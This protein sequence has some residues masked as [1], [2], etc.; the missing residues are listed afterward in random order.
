MS[1]Q[2]V[3]LLFAEQTSPFDDEEL[4][5][6]LVGIFTDE[7]ECLR[8]QKEQP[9]Y[10]ISWEERD[11]EDA[12]EHT[13]EPG[14]TVYAYHYMATYRPTPDGGEAIEL[15][16]DAPVEDVFFQE[17]NARKKLEVGDLQVITVGDFRLKGDF[18]I[19]EG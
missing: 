11:V 15:L 9:R 8:I 10:K 1:N 18:Q 12:G 3:Y 17:G 16:S 19:I 7:A 6:P 5:D 2:T 14:D 13:I 4:I